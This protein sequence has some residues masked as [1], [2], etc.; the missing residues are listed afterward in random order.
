MRPTCLIASSGHHALLRSLKALVEPE[1]EVVA[2]ADNLLSLLD[3][4]GTLSPDVAII[5]LPPGETNTLRH[6]RQRYPD[7]QVVAVGDDDDAVVR[8]EALSQG[9]ASYVAKEAAATDLLPA[10]R[11]ALEARDRTSAGEEQRPET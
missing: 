2:M 9:A 1:C 10:V 7:L 11:A 3:A 6:L 5:D 8:K 4:V